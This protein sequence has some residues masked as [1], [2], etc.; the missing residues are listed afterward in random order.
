VELDTDYVV[1]NDEHGG[2]LAT[3]RLLETGHRDILLLG[4]PSHISSAAE[5]KQ[6]YLRAYA[7]LGLVPQKELMVE[8]PITAIASAKAI[9]LLMGKKVRFDAIFAFSD[10]IAWKSWACLAQ[11]G[12]RVPEDVS[13]IGFDYINSRLDLPFQLTSVSS[14]KRRMSTTAVNIL[15]KLIQQKGIGKQAKTH[16]ILNTTLSEGQSV[17]EK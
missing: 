3:K 17:A 15:L 13:V 2:Y 8:V 9:D 12:L 4:G 16:I 11:Q 5:R 1:C 10:I 14:Q 6:G 7:E